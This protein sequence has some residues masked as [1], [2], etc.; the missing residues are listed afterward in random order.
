MSHVQNNCQQ[1]GNKKTEAIQLTLKF[2]YLKLVGKLCIDFAKFANIWRVFSFI[3][4]DSSE[5][6]FSRY[7]SKPWNNDG[8]TF[9]TSYMVMVKF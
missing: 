5:N 8:D 2:I 4:T 9:A 3:R 6:N 1:Q 7:P